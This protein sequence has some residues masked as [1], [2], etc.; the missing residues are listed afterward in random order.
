[1]LAKIDGRTKES[2]LRAAARAEL[3]RHVGGSPNGIQRTL[4]ERAAR[5]MLYIEVMDRETLETGTMSERASR[6]YLAW[7][8]SAARSWRF[9]HR[10]CKKGGIYVSMLLK[11]RASLRTGPQ[12]AATQGVLIAASFEGASLAAR[13]RPSPTAL[14]GSGRQNSPPVSLLTTQSS[15]RLDRHF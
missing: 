12:T 6:Q 14:E 10:S 4:I 8:S 3:T 15:W 5:L 13:S 7:S 11:R 9:P 2:R 1:M